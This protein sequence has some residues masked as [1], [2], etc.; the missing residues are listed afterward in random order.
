MLRIRCYPAKRARQPRDR[1]AAFQAVSL[2][3]DV[4]APGDPETASEALFPVAPARGSHQRTDPG[5][6]HAGA[7]S[8]H[9]PWRDPDVGEEAVSGQW[10]GGSDPCGKLEGRSSETVAVGKQSILSVSK[11]QVPL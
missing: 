4:W 10:R 3:G 2:P 5:D 9:P 6:P 7:V 11:T 1:S 8:D